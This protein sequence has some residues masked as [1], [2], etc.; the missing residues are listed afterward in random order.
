[1][2][3]KKKILEK[4]IIDLNLTNLVKLNP[5]VENIFPYINKSRCL[6]L[7]SFWEDPGFVILEA[8]ACRTFIISSDCNN[9]PVEILEND[10][11]GLLF[12]TNNNE[13]FIRV[14]SNYLKLS[15]IEI[16]KIKKNALKKAKLFTI[17]SHAK[18]FVQI[19][20]NQ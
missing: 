5:F 6:I 18:N 15:E 1:M 4:L 20:N 13:D 7:S 17:F 8:A 10:K 9:G 12:K 16:N 2:V 3:K 14:F 11:A 19:L